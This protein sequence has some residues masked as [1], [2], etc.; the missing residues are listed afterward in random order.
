MSSVC[1]HDELPCP[2]GRCPNR[3][4]ACQGAASSVPGVP[5]QHGQP[6]TNPQQHRALKARRYG[7]SAVVAALVLS[8]VGLGPAGSVVPMQEAG[9]FSPGDTQQ[10]S[11]VETVRQPMAATPKATTIPPETSP[12]SAAGRATSEADDVDPAESP[13]LDFREVAVALSAARPQRKVL[14]RESTVRAAASA[15]GA[16]LPEG[17][18]TQGDLT[19]L[20]ARAWKQA[21]GAM[22]LAGIDWGE[23][24]RDEGDL[25]RA[26]RRLGVE[27]GDQLQP[28]DVRRVLERGRWDIARQL[29]EGRFRIGKRLDMK[30]I[31][32]AAHKFDLRAG[33]RLY[34]SSVQRIARRV[35]QKGRA[36]WEAKNPTPVFAK[37]SG[38]ELRLP[39]H[40]VRYAGFHQAA[41]PDAK[42]MKKRGKA[43]THVLP[44]RRRGTGRRTAIDVVL[45]P[46]RDVRAPATGRVVKVQR[47]SL[48]GK[49]PDHRIEIRSGRTVTK[50]LH[51]KNPKVRPG[52]RVRAGRTVI[53]GGARKFP[54]SSQV[55]SFAGKRWGHVH[56]EVSR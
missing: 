52:Q 55:D 12:A 39:N 17:D 29:R 22:T 10:A 37:V 5:L 32:R 3:T 53:A 40:D 1:A 13:A 11:T 42:Q 54:F 41:Y 2:F 50:V 18:L 9:T 48:Y 38:V 56:I 28:R 15:I 31:R 33:E 14:P 36:R 26:A 34:P 51:V 21:G 45:A 30:D 25:R 35:A 49:Y 46:G 27:V 24:G 6:S 43:R 23:D 44:S 47:Y 16:Q 7:L 8:G 4:R 20:T 19:R